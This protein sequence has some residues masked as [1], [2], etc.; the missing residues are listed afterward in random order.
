MPSKLFVPTLQELGKKLITDP[1]KLQDYTMRLNK[2]KLNALEERLLVQLT[3]PDLVNA[4]LDTIF[5][6]YENMLKVMRRETNIVDYW[7]DVQEI[8]ALKLDKTILQSTAFLN[9]TLASLY[10]WMEGDYAPTAL[11]FLRKL[12]SVTDDSFV[13]QNLNEPYDMHYLRIVLIIMSRY[14]AE[15]PSEFQLLVYGTNWIIMFV[16]LGLDLDKATGEAIT[17]YVTLENREEAGVDLA[18]A[19]LYNKAEIGVDENGVIQTPADWLDKWRVYSH[20][21]LDGMSLVNFFNDKNVWKY[22]VVEEKEVVKE[23]LLVYSYLVSDKYFLMDVD[24]EKVKTSLLPTPPPAPKPVVKEPS[25]TVGM[26]R[27]E[28][29]KKFKKDSQ[30]NYLEEEKVLGELADLAEKYH[31]DEIADWYY[32]DDAEKKFKWME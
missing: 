5:L 13:F 25:V 21:N 6:D 30:G 1:A 20:G 32:W 18:T 24:L 3:P 2:L 15:L 26:I 19:I 4:D 22:C 10:I 17:H 14:F 12:K 8:D 11:A 31:R 29:D 16:A 27:V 28:I 23:I 9:T 7:V